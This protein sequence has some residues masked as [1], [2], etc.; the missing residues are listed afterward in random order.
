[1]LEMSFASFST[2]SIDVV[3]S[4]TTV[5]F[6]GSTI[7]MNKRQFGIEMMVDTTFCFRK[8]FFIGNAFS[9]STAMVPYLIH[10]GE[11]RVKLSGKNLH[12]DLNILFHN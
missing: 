1:L 9:N 2:L 4:Y 3:L 7:N 6:S 5:F 8:F 11:G 10:N 12:E